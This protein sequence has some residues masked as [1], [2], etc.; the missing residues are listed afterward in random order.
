VSIVLKITVK[1][2]KKSN[3]PY[4]GV[5]FMATS[6]NKYHVYAANPP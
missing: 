2:G 3:A 4:I 1:I 6:N 5:Y